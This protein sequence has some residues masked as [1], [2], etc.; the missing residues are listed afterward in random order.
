MTGYNVITHLLY[1]LR[2]A[3]LAIPGAWLLAQVEERVAGRYKP[4]LISQ[5][6]LGAVVF[7]VDR[8]IFGR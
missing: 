1:I 5:V 8:W 2:W 3:V 6:T 4:M 7:F